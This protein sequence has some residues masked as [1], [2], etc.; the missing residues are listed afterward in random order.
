MFPFATL[1]LIGRVHDGQL[2]SLAPD[3][4]IPSLDL[5]LGNL[6]P[7]PTNTKVR[8]TGQISFDANNKPM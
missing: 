4:S 2:L 3:A 5:N 6:P 1:T 7:I 8:L